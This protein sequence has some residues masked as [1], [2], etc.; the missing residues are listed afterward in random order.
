MQQTIDNFVHPIMESKIKKR[1]GRPPKNQVIEEY[2]IAIP[3]LEI[4][5][6]E[7]DEIIFEMTR[8]NC[9][10]KLSQESYY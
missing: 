6:Q 10:R 2:E 9:D 1:L 5:Q 8:N 3:P 4:S 7:I